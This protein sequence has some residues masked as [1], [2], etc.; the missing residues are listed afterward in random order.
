MIKNYFV[1][2]M[3]CKSNTAI[4]VGITSNLIKRCDDHISGKGSKFTDKY[5][6]KKLIYYEWTR[7]LLN[8]IAREK[9]IKSWNRKKKVSLINSI[10]PGWSEISIDD[11]IGIKILA[12]VPKPRTI[13]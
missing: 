3:T 13:I 7:Y 12:F 1:Y 2:I 4:Y 6:C 8:A 10:N 9:E 5:K 11:P